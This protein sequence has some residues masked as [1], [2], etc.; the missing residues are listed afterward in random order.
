ME[1]VQRKG[2]RGSW[3]GAETSG[4]LGTLTRSHQHSYQ[5]PQTANGNMAFYAVY[6]FHVFVCSVDCVPKYPRMRKEKVMRL[7][8]C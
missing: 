5:Y 7:I 1:F 6:A 4:L 2:G 8:L 3:G